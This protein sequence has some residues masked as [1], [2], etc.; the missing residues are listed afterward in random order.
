LRE[1]VIVDGV[2]IPFGRAG[3]R[4]ALRDISSSE[5]IVPVLQA[6]VK[7]NKLDPKHV[8]EFYLGSYGDED[9]YYA[10]YPYEA[11]GI[12]GAQHMGK[13]LLSRQC[14]ASLQGIQLAAGNI[15]CNWADVV[16]V[17]GLDLGGRRGPFRPGGPPFF[18]VPGMYDPPPDPMPEGWKLAK[19]L[20][21]WTDLLPPDIM[22]MLQTGENV[23]ERFG[24]TREE[25]DLFACKS[26]KKCEE[27]YDAGR[28]KDH[29]IPLT[30]EY[31]DGSS[32]TIEVDQGLRRSTT[33][34][35]LAGLRPVLK[36]NGVVT[37]GNSCPQ[38]DGAS[39]VL[40]MSKEKAKELGMTPLVT[41]RDSL[42]VGVDP[43]VMGIGPWKATEKLLKKTGRKIEE[44]DLIE[45]NEAFAAQCVPFQRELGVP[46]EKINVNG[47]A[48]A[49]G[50]PLGATGCRLVMQAA[51]ELKRRD[52]RWA[53]A[54]LC[55]GL[56]Q[57]MAMFLEREKYS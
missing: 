13:V 49:I 2:R 5:M 21:H 31:E 50:H 32:N 3:E 56:G 51:F 44:F 9:N 40:V 24:V 12:E 1:A 14:A 48:I 15:M 6:L 25:A 28:F 36:E 41:V 43:E 38:N 33:L 45:L 47:G 23:A 55:I 18:S 11:F 57:G 35:G 34:E 52:A 53:I 46:D 26:Q 54:T 30:I 4:G 10:L 8:D 29:V 42:A 20:P 39:A 7:R 17:G 19:M 37:A 27:A 22:N 16:I